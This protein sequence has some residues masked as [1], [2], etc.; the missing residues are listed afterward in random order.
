MKP[1]L[2]L[3]V[4]AFVCTIAV[5]TVTTRSSQSNLDRAAQRQHVQDVACSD[6]RPGR[7]DSA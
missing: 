1:L 2:S 6:G 4:L 7:S 3:V 5:G